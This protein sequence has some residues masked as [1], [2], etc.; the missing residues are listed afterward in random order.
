MIIYPAI[1]IKSGKCVRLKQGVF[2]DVTV[3][4]EN[5]A[6]QAISWENLGASYIHV[7]DLD[8]ARSG[9]TLN[10]SLNETKIAEILRSVN[11]PIQVGGGIRTIE[12]IKRK[13]A[14]GVSRVI[15]GTTAVTNPI[16]VEEAIA[17]FGEER[18]A[19]GIDARDGIARISAWEETGGTKALELC[20]QMKSYGVKTII[21]TDI[22]KDG[23]LL[24][25]NIDETKRVIDKTGLDIIASGGVSNLR[26]L[27]EIKAI[28][29]A[30]AI[31][32]K[33]LYI[34]AIDLT[35]AISQNR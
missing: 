24:G 23:M 5:P 27:K 28:G 3:Y 13:L 32:G 20:L 31:I 25:P 2:E 9:G 35:I 15:I 33:A 10:D 18:I 22:S 12:D 34:G 16:I 26:D 17:L 8:G 6:T 19:V 7:V 4:N 29:A 11:I 30:G 14:M 21:Y 1:D